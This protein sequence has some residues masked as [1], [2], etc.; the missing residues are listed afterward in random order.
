MSTLLKCEKTECRDLPV[1]KVNE[2][3]GTNYNLLSPVSQFRRGP[4]AIGLY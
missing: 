4:R 3:T 1:L 2:L